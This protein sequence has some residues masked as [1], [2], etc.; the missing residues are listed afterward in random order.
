MKFEVNWI[1]IYTVYLQKI[2]HLPLILIILITLVSSISFVTLYSAAGMNFYPWCYRQIYFFLLFLPVMLIIA[3]IDLKWIF[4]SSYILFFLVLILLLMIEIIGHTAMGAK[5]WLNLGIIKLQPAELCK[6]TIVMML[7]RYFHSQKLS[8]IHRIIPVIIPAI[9]VLC[10]ALLVIKQPD[11]GTGLVILFVSG[12]VFF[13]AGVRIWK[14]ALL[15][16]TSLLLSP[17]LWSMLYDYQKKRILTFLDPSQD[18]LGA[19]YNIMQSRIAIGSG[20]MFGKGIGH[21]T[22]S[23]LNFLPEHQTDFIFS[24]FVEENGFIG[25]AI[26]CIL[27]LLIILYSI[28]IA[29]RSKSLYGKLLTIGII[30]IFS[31]H[32]FINISMVMGLLPAVGIPLPFMSYGRTMMGSMMIGFGLIMNVHIHKY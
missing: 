15:F 12:I 30:S 24:T 11:L 14:F 17:I 29:Q 28:R 27:Y 9:V 8:Q 3:L 18:R 5:R 10:E 25:G 2:Y 26:L 1:K 31:I 32:I 4:R 20:G 13:V 16:V 19:G 21:G 6:I 7:A 22:Q 23:Q